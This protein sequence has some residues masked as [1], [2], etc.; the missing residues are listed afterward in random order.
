VRGLPCCPQGTEPVFKEN[1]RLYG[2]DRRG[3][4]GIVDYQLLSENSCWAKKYGKDCCIFSDTPITNVD[5][6]GQWGEEFGEECGIVDNSCWSKRLGYKCC[7]DPNVKVDYVDDDG[8]W[9]V[10]NDDWC[11]IIETTVSNSVRKSAYKCVAE[12]LGYQCCSNKNTVSIYTDGNGD[13]GSE[14]GKWC[15]L[16]PFKYELDPINN[17]TAYE[18]DPI[19]PSKLPEIASECWAEKQNELCCIDPKTTEITSTIEGKWGYEDNDWCGIIDVQLIECLDENLSADSQYKCCKNPNIEATYTDSDGTWAVENNDWCIVKQF[20]NKID[21]DSDP[22]LCRDE[23]LSEYNVNDYKC[24]TEPFPSYYSTEGKIVWGYE[25]DYF[26]VIEITD[27]NVSNPSTTTIQ[28]EPNP[29]T[30]TVEPEPTKVPMDDPN[31]WSSKYGY[32]CCSPGSK[33]AMSDSKGQWGIEDGD[34]CGLVENVPNTCWAE[35]FGYKCCSDNIKK[36]K[37]QTDGLWGVEDNH[38]CGLLIFEENPVTYTIKAVTSTVN[39]S[40]KTKSQTETITSSSI[41]TTTTKTSTTTKSKTSTTTKTTTSTITTTTTSQTPEPTI[42]AGPNQKCGG[43]DYTGP[44]C[45]PSG[46]YCKKYSDYYYGCAD[47][48]YE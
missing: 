44:T 1:G 23:K 45:C 20:A 6:R 29:S 18:P 43:I 46:Y 19:D 11:G 16:T 4:C 33:V 42:C 12:P 39:D 22:I 48:R 7:D 31:C 13:W 41:L 36:I 34:W 25:N 30:T 15:G 38:W 37:S 47:E 2:Y 14:N 32:K 40:S 8:K 26:C 21:E 17:T 3:Y 24:C 35:K 28:P 9:G 27:L 5:E 10:E